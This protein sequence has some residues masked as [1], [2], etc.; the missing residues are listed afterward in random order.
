MKPE[1]YDKD[2]E[3]KYIMYYDV[4]NLYGCAMRHPLPYSDFKWVDEKDFGHTNFFVKDES[5]VGYILE[6]DLEYPKELHDERKDLPFCP[7][8]ATPPGAKQEKFLATLYDKEKFVIHY[9]YLE[10]VLDSGLK[11]KKIHRVLQFQQRPW[12][13]SYIDLNTRMR[14]NSTNEFEKK[15]YKL[16]NNAIYGN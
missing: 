1:N 3:V 10:Q 5:P 11:I 6:V 7:E 14:T 15:F 8:H 16:M 13:A 12:L 2:E 4:N 9:K